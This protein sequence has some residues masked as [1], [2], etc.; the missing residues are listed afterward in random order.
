MA[1]TRL[2]QLFLKVED[3]E[4]TAASSLFA[5]A[6]G[7]YL[8]IDPSMTFEVETYQRDIARETFTP[9][10]PVAGAVLGT[11]SFTLEAAGRTSGALGTRPM[12]DIPLVACGFRRDRLYRFDVSGAI[13]NGP[14][15]HGTVITQTATG[16][17]FTTIG[18][19]YDGASYIWAT[20]GLIG[21]AGNFYLGTGTPGVGTGF[22]FPGSGSFTTSANPSET[23]IGWYP[24]SVPLYTIIFNASQSFLAGSTIVGNTSK[25][26]AIAYYAVSSSTQCV[27]RRVSGSFTASETVSIYNPDGTLASGS[28]S[29]ASSNVFLQAD[30]VCRTASIGV[31]KD[32]VFESMKGCRGSVNITGNIG[33]PVLFN[34]TFQGIKESVYDSGNVAGITY[35]TLVPPVLLGATVTAGDA[36]ISTLGGQRTMCATTFGIDMTADVQYRRCMSAATGIDGIYQ[37]GRTPTLT[38]NPEQSPELDFDVMANYFAANTTR[39]NIE[40]GSTAANKFR[41][42]MPTMTLQSVGQ[43]DR[44]GLITRDL[45][46]ALNS[47]SSSSVSGDNEFAIIWD[48]GV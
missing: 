38:L 34:F 3:V 19:Y 39:M 22:T 43:G 4:G 23:A 17:T 15:T 13:T 18:T 44:N 36:G 7:K 14:V 11:A 2:Q 29:L 47:G 27:A 25:A 21:G 8:A 42:N 40:V 41:F 31:A 20:Q 48:T 10:S 35:D 9:L 32:G 5:S 33:E 1:L 6:N 45:T 28:V 46:F 12:F 37:N 30:N 26:I 16:A 24:W